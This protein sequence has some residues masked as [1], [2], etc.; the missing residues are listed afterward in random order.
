MAY[1]IEIAPAAERQLKALSKSLQDRIVQ[2]LLALQATPRPP[3]VKKLDSDIYR[4]R[5]GDYRIIYQIQ[6]QA[7]LI[8]V[9]RV[10]H[11]KDVYR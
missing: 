5:V 4:V 9:L 10:R 3:G 6:D 8:L 11:R 7:L 2:Q 1:T